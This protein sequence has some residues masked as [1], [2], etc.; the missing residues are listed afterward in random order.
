MYTYI[1]K[2]D[3]NAKITEMEGKIPS[4]TGS[5][6]TAALNAVENK[7]PDDYNLVK[8]TDHDAKISDIESKCFTA[9]DYN[10]TKIK[11]KGLIDKSEIF[12]FISNADLG[13]K[14]ATLATKAKLKAEQY[15]IIKLQ[16]ILKTMVL[17]II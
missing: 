11:Q 3:Y 10:K 17:K 5:S 15:K 8:K 4:I 1:K 2:T 6:T 12:G 16:F 13:K 7:I 14:V 9:T